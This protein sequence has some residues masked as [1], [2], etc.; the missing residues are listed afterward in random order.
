MFK[1]PFSFSG[2]I[3]RSE[4][5]I[6]F[7]L[8]CIAIALV[9]VIIGSLILDNGSSD[10]SSDG[11]GAPLLFFIL[12]IPMLWFLWA[13]G[14]KRCHDLGNSGWWQFIPFYVLWLIFA[15]GEPGPNEYGDNPKGIG[16]NPQFTFEQSQNVKAEDGFNGEYLG[17]HNSSKG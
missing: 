7:I 8:C 1:A 14:A 11:S 4:F 13:Q 17:G 2:R 12:L 16:N 3:R 9:Q 6:S 5:G 15:D 10:S